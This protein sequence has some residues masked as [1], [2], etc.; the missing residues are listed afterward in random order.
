[1]SLFYHPTLDFSYISVS[2]VNGVRQCRMS[3]ND[4]ILLKVTAHISNLG[5]SFQH[6]SA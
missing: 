3:S 6:Y 5:Y 1:M 4:V 2:T